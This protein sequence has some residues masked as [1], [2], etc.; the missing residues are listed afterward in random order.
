MKIGTLVKITGEEALDGAVMGWT[1]THDD[2][3]IHL[4]EEEEVYGIFLGD[5]IMS[6][7]VPWYHVLVGDRKFL[8][9]MKRIKAVDTGDKNI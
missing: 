1:E 3:D 2:I 9:L 6:N 5:P 4:F 7:N 8:F